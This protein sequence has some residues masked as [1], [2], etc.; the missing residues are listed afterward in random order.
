M[1]ECNVLK[2]F[3]RKNAQKCWNGLLL[4]REKVLN[5]YVNKQTFSIEFQSFDRYQ[6][7]GKNDV[8]WP[9]GEWQLLF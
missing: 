6:T 5:V 4:F 1:N 9:S 2:K 8:R 3:T 7:N